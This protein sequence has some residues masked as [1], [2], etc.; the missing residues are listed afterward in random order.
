MQPKDATFF[1]KLADNSP[2]FIGMCDMR[3]VPFYINDA[4][5]RLVG[6]EDLKHFQNTPVNDFF[7]PEDQDFIVNQFFPRVLQE[8]RAETEIRFR[9][10]RT[11]E[12][13]WMTY[14]VFFLEGDD[15]KPAGLA[16]VSR[17][18]SEQKR[19]EEALRES[20][21]RFASFMR[22]LPGFAWVKDTD[23]RYVFVN[24]TIEKALQ[25]SRENML[26]RTDRELFDFQS[27]A[28]Y[29]LNDVEALASEG[30]ITAVETVLQIDGRQHQLLVNKFPIRDAKGTKTGVGGV[31]IDVTER[32]EAQTKLQEALDSL[33]LADRSKD[34][35][36]ATLA[37]ELRNPLTPISNGLNVLRALEGENPNVTRIEQIMSRQ[38]NHLVRL[39][40]DLV[41]VERIGRGKISLQNRLLDVREVLEESVDMSRQF[42]EAAGVQLHMSLP[43]TP[44]HVVGDPVRLIQIF[45]NLLNNAAK[46]SPRGG[47]VELNATRDND[48]VVVKVSDNGIGISRE[49]L[50]HV[51]D[52]FL[53]G[54][55]TSLGIK[56]GLGVGLALVRKLTEL[57]GGAVEAQSPG[58][59]LGS[60]FTVRLPRAQESGAVA[61]KASVG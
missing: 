43:E 22:H 38:L 1:R 59:N 41:D 28:Q 32:V 4:G 54:E 18:I 17:D 46:F 13:I 7:F 9:H 24:E 10:F 8:G 29:R 31:A 49:L 57:H 53:Q 37:H 25:M 50:P 42:I 45:S 36:L 33:R 60:V 40:D 15:G 12:A 61:V 44:L 47:C 35:F 14:D 2:L 58:E 48:S 34:E 23:G 26:G 20:E 27:A 30:G 55:K 51:F 39:V 52:L 16:T 21:E 3:L 5:R 19:I 6:L 11:G 56:R